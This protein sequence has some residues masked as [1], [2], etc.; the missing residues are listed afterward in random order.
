MKRYIKTTMYEYLN[1]NKK[2]IFDD[3]YHGGE[4]DFNKPMYFTSEFITSTYGKVSGPYTLNINNYIIIDF[5]NAE[6]WWLSP[7]FAQIEAKKLDMVLVDFNKYKDFTDIAS[8][9]TD[10]FVKASLERGFDGIIFKNIMD[11]G[12]LQVKGNKW[13]RHDNIVASNPKKSVSIN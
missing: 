2:I 10:H 4:V 11:S 13:I 3:L 6:G 7:E 12:S 1:E 5:T 9:K 8:I